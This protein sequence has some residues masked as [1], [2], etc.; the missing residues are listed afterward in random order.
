MRFRIFIDC[1]M[2]SKINF[3]EVQMMSNKIFKI[4]L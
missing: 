1:E 3:Y 4:H 2:I